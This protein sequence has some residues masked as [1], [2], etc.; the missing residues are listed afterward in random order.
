M[1]LLSELL[2]IKLVM[3]LFW[4]CAANFLDRSRIFSY[5]RITGYF[6]TQNLLWNNHT[7]IYMNL[8][9]IFVNITKKTRFKKTEP[10]DNW[11]I[12]NYFLLNYI[13]TSMK[14]T[15]SSSWFAK[16]TFILIN[17]IKYIVMRSA[18]IF[19]RNFCKISEKSI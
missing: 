11:T 14:I 2:T 16:K 9:A 8:F 17:Y 13:I 12:L 1:F 6:F 3:S 19:K 18:L 7:S 10:F 4:Q 15:T 5:K